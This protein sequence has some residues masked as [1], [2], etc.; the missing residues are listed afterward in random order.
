M[1]LS[2]DKVIIQVWKGGREGEK[3]SENQGRRF[4]YAAEGKV[5]EVQFAMALTRS[6]KMV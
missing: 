5:V 4:L 1:L 6:S 3:T 2:L